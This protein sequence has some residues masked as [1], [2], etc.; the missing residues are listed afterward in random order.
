[1]RNSISYRPQAGL[2]AKR[3]NRLFIAGLIALAISSLVLT[4]CNMDLYPED[5]LSTATYFTSETALKEYSNYFY[6]MMPDPETMYA[7]EGEH[8]VAPVPNDMV[9]GIRDIHSGEAYWKKDAWRNL[10]KINYLLAN[11]HQCPD[12][13]GRNHYMGVAYFFR[14]YFYFDMLRYFGA[15]PW[16]NDPINADDDAA[17]KRPRDS[18]EVI[19]RHIISDLDSAYLL[20]PQ[21]PTPYEVN[22][23]TALALKS[24]A[25]LFE[26]TFR[27]Y[28]AGSTFNGGSELYNEVLPWDDLLQLSADASLKLM[29]EGG[30]SLHTTGAEPYRE[31]FATTVPYVEEIIWARVYSKD[32]DI[33]HNAQAWSV[34]RATGFTKRFADIYPMTDGSPF[35]GQAGFDTLTYI[36]VFK[37]RDPRMAQTIH[38]PGYIQMGVDKSYAVNLQ[39]TLTGYKY[40]KYIMESTY[41]TWGGSVC[42]MPIFRLAEIY[43]NYAEAKA[44]LGTLTQADLDIS[45]NL[46]RDRVG[47][48]HL[49]MANANAA[50]D[51]SLTDENGYGFSSPILLAHPN[52]GVLL[53]IR[54]ER[55]IETPLEGLHVWDIMRWKEGHLFTLPRLGL[56]FPREG[57]YDLTG[58]GKAN[59]LISPTKKS[60]GIGVTCLVMDQDIF[61]SNTTSGNMVAYKDM[62]MQWKEDKDYLYPIPIN[63]RT[64]TLGSL[65]QNPGWNDG[66]K[67]E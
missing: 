42:A 1:M 56:Y 3:S 46:L 62:I 53:E 18:R 54:R 32:L 47:V 39:M 31:L 9:R 61:L 45:V 59:I 7:E 25:C 14:A 11:A 58:D 19:I 65:I 17:L 27:K 48:T 10:R 2:T 8:F 37:N 41:N 51:A 12:E 34:A 38:A 6:R 44:E 4:S 15:V 26:G 30:Y 5:E 24:R 35:T 29:Q 50:P 23:Y 49:N 20:L 57:K 66:L 55:M 63:D 16:Y 28:H 21:S 33:K 60:G 67:F 43:L 22:A 64:M 52:K 13:K 40:I 36:D